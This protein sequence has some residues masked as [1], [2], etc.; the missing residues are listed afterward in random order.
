MKRRRW[1]P[2]SLVGR[3]M[4]VLIAGLA[5]S[6]LAAI[7]F[8]S[9]SR[10]DLT[11]RLAYRQ[12]AERIVSNVQMIEESDE[13]E[14]N[15]ILRAARREGFYVRFS[16]EPW[17]NPEDR[18]KETTAILS[19]LKKEL[20]DQTIVASLGP[21]PPMMI[22]Q[23]QE[24]SGPPFGM[25]GMRGGHGFMRPHDSMRPPP[26]LTVSVQ[27]GDGSWVNFVSPIDIPDTS[28]QTSTLLTP[29]LVGLFVV[30]ALSVLA[31]WS[32]SKPLA[33]LANAA[34]RLGRD[35][36]A[37]PVPVEGPRE[38]RSAA[39]AFN[40][41]QLRLKR[42]I[43]DRTQM[44]AAI[45]HDLRTPITR[46]KLRAEFIEDDETRNKML[47][48]LDEIEAMIKQT[49][50]FG[51]ND[52]AREPRST[53]D[54]AMMLI[55]LCRHFGNVYKGPD[56]LEL[57]AGPISL[58]RA[59]TNLLE[60]AHKYGHQANIVLEDGKDAVLIVIDDQGPGIREL[61]MERVFQPFF[62]LESSRNRDTGGTGLGLA[63]ARSAIRAH[64]G[65]I[66]LSNRPEGGL[67]ATVTL[68]R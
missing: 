19:E 51:R 24:G 55:D 18:N 33:V 27:I 16:A 9:L 11:T 58:K 28:G 44:I 67:R 10:E 68:P 17:A 32:A 5:L 60:N 56:H 34:E 53:I 57:L 21:P 8:F 1:F 52:S 3:T 54:L 62:R 66:V 29:L 25:H 23:G 59:L 47:S 31:V 30:L 40:N 22:Q 6:Q 48:D 38:V 50:A 42:F 7:V 43:D 49:L 37:P 14:R 39:L 35:V 46:M 4:L 20:T 64:G 12:L 36:G 13:F 15:R 41:M 65:D 2:D 61:D 26:L 63:I 45:S